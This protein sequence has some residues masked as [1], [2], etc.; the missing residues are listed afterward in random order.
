[1]YLSIY[2]SC[3]VEENT[4]QTRKAL[5]REIGLCKLK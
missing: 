2:L 4:E 3:L 1:M 5:L